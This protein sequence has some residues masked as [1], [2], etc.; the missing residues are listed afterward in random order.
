[1]IAK[2]LSPRYV[3]AEASP[4][5]AAPG[6]AVV[7]VN[8]G[9]PDAPTPAAVRRYLAEFLWDPRVIEQ[10]RWLWW[11][12]LR[13]ILLIRPRRSARAYAEI[14]TEAGSP[15]MVLTRA[16]AD[17][18]R[19]RWGAGAPE[20]HVA[21]RYGRPAVAEVMA[22]LTRRGVR[23]L[24]VVPLYP[25]YSATSTGAVLDAVADGIKRLRW[26]P[27]LRLVDDY[28]A[29]PAYI[30]ALAASVEAHWHVHGRADRLLLSFHGIPQRYVAAGDPYAAQCLATAQRLRERLGLGE[31]AVL[32]T[33]QSRVGRE[34]WLQPY[35]DRT[36]AALP[37]QGVRSVQVICPGFAVDCL[38]T[39]EEIAMGGRE[40]F[41]HA[42]GERYEYIAAL[43][44][45]PAQVELITRL[46][47][48]TAQG[49]AE[50]ALD[51]A[52]SAHA[53][54]GD[55]PCPDPASGHRT[56]VPA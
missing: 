5:G 43:N 49:W 4:T 23:R 19:A 34:P 56:D 9:T 29:D 39:L 11:L 21:M 40:T 27:Q 2:I 24:V 25:Q 35:T 47:A 33:F 31:D 28:H 46:V 10:P 42:G 55:Q 16:L 26:P 38:E 41:L 15:L 7:L 44:A 6:A 30:E 52:A 13:V 32:T 54:C 45:E 20:V 37:D 3:A 53:P 12:I 50:F 8:L 36:L 51:G 22:E 18:L 14:W 48:Q 1:M 17:A